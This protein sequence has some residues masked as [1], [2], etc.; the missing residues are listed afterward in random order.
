MPKRKPEIGEVHV[1]CFNL[2]RAVWHGQ[3]KIHQS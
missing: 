2:Y 3:L 1:L